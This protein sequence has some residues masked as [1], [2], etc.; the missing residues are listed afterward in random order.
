[1][2]PPANGVILPSFGVVQAGGTSSPLSSRTLRIN[3]FVMDFELSAPKI[4]KADADT[5]GAG[6]YRRYTG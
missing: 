1:M 2:D 6:R 5:T 3:L 4:A